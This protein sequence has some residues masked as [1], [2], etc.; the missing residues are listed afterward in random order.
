MY[1]SNPTWLTLYRCST[2]DHQREWSRGISNSD[3]IWAL[4]CC[5]RYTPQ[6]LSCSRRTS[7]LVDLDNITQVFYKS[8]I[9]WSSP[10]TY[11]LEQEET[12]TKTIWSNVWTN[13]GIATT[14]IIQFVE[15]KEL[16]VWWVCKSQNTFSIISNSLSTSPSSRLPFSSSQSLSC[17]SPQSHQSIFAL[18]SIYLTSPH[19]TTDLLHQ[20]LDHK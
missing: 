4:S 16:T 10:A 9:H 14:R 7:T 20:W 3:C 19:D 1:L 13:F 12:F 17:P 2:T 5:C 18:H 8:Y 11:T 15:F 6:I